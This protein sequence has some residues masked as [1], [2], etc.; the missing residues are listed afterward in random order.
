MQEG[1]LIYNNKLLWLIAILLFCSIAVYEL[2]GFYYVLAIPLL[3]EYLF[4]VIHDWKKAY[5][6]L[7]FT[8][9]ISIQFTI[10]NHGLS[11]SFPD[12]P[13]AWIFLFLTLIILAEGKHTIPKG[14]WR[15]PITLIILLQFVWLV[16][17]VTYSEM[18][19]FSLKFLLAKVWYVATFF[20][21]PIWIFREK[22][23]F[24][25]GYKMVL[26]P[27]L[28][29]MFIIMIRYSFYE[30]KFANISQA[31]GMLYYNHVEYSTVLSMIFPLVLTAYIISKE[32]GEQ[33]SKKYFIL[34][35]F[36]LLCVFFA[37]AR[38]A[39]IAVVF[40]VFVGWTIK[41]QLVN[42]IMPVIYT[43]M[44]LA[45]LYMS[46]DRKYIEYRPK[47]DHTLMHDNF[48]D[49]ILA[50]FKGRDI[51]SMERFHRWIAAIRMSND[52]PITGFGPHSFYYHYKPYTVSL[53]KT[54]ASEN[55]ERSTTHNYFLLMLVEQGIPAML[56]YA[57]L[58]I[59]VFAQA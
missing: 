53:F 49:H 41:K 17:A 2:T 32:A 12:E 8:I 34:I 57:L 22:K 47:Y 7:L 20:I 29:T 4:I 19:L 40:A 5:W 43:F 9:P 36:F 15:N 59:I 35:T 28:I 46:N 11:I 58:I 21:V 10:I 52:R 45:F 51:S 33:K 50:T 31:V 16:V 6:I 25:K 23:D 26:I 56:L 44:L 30:F 39:M 18:L 48:V 1:I 42:Y 13:I 3:L 24:I 27:L 38:A 55:V 54:Y 37:F 14:W